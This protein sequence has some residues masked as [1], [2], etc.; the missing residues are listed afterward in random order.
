MIN[1]KETLRLIN[2]R[3]VSGTIKATKFK[4]SEVETDVAAHID[5]H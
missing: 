2:N 1:R 4:N 5:R 3:M